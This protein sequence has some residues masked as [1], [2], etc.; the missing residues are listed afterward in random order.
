MRRNPSQGITSPR[1]L[2]LPAVF[3][4]L[5]ALLPWL[6]DRLET[7]GWPRNPGDFTTEVIGS[8]ITLLLGCWILSLIRREQRYTLRHLMELERLTLTDPLTG[9]ANRRALERDLVLWLSRGERLG[10]PLALL[11]MDVDHLKLINDQHGHG[12][13]DET[14][15]TLGAVLRSCSRLGTDS[16]YRVGGDEFV[17]MMVADG[18][19][20]ERLAD[21]LKREFEL[22]SPKGSR[23]S[24]GVVVW[25]GHA[26]ASQLL[27]QADN[28][29]YES[30][31]RGWVTRRA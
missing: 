20:A 11:Y 25:D 31:R 27:D 18:R 23:L 13:G 19:G 22:R 15:R 6:T 21:R 24:L 29:M 26:S 30:R 4:L 9:L 17:M 10:D 28:Q 12:V 1:L 14:L 7:G 2:I 16:A 3:I 5:V 8:G